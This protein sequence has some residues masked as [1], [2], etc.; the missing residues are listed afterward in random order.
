MCVAKSRNGQDTNKQGIQHIYYYKYVLIEKFNN[1][2]IPCGPIY[3]IDEMFET[4]RR[5][6]REEAHQG[7]V[8]RT[9]L[10]LP[11]RPMLT[12]GNVMNA[13]RR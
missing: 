6:R 10:N 13:A 11:F 2:G 8:V 12:D 4:R 7:N 5:R 3:S 9:A 1:A